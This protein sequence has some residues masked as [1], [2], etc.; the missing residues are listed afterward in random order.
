MYSRKLKMLFDIS[1]NSNQFVFEQLIQAIGPK[2]IIFDS[3]LP[4][5]HMRARRITENSIY[6]NIVPK[7]FYGDVSGDKNMRE[8]SGDEAEKITF[9]LYEEIDAFKRAA[10][11]T[12]LTPANI[13]DILYT[14]TN[15]IISSA[16]LS[17]D[18]QKPH[19]HLPYIFTKP[20]LTNHDSEPCGL[21]HSFFAP[22]H[23]TE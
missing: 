14:N 16:K 6:I 22:L 4:I 3:D 15:S 1:A 8:V 10:L 17:I 5:L 20:P 13:E 7:G 2:R 19:H 12:N 9:F 21:P 18:D 11:T 23:W